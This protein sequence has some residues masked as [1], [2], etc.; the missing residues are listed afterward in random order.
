M[1]QSNAFYVNMLQID[2][3]SVFRCFHWWSPRF[4]S[5][6]GESYPALFSLLVIAETIAISRKH[7]A[8]MAVSYWEKKN[9]CEWA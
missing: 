4:L 9:V 1:D 6:L 8:C 7:E 3:L 5:I 2:G